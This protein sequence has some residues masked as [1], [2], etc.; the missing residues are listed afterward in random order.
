MGFGLADD[1]IQLDTGEVLCSDEQKL[2][3]VYVNGTPIE[4]PSSYVNQEEDQILVYYGAL[5][6][7]KLPD[8]LAMVTD[9][10]CIYSGTCPERGI[11]PPESCGLTCELVP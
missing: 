10:S 8:Y 11:A 6:N 9:E 1:C 3:V 4:H 7:P 2:L 5:D